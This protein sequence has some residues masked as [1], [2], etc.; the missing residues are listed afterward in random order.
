MNWDLAFWQAFYQS[1]NA[2]AAAYCIVAIGLN[3]H[4]GYTGLLNF[5]QAGFAAVGAYAFAVPIANYDWAWY[6]AIPV[7]VVASVLLSLLL[8]LPT[9]R[10]RADYLAIVTIAAAEIIRFSLNSTRFTWLT[11][12]SNGKQGW[13]R[14]FQDL[15]PWPNGGRYQIGAQVFDG[16]RLFMMVLGWSLVLLA[17]LLVWA[18]M[19]S[20]WGRVLKSIR[21]DEDAARALGKNVV[22]FKMQSLVLGGLLGSFGGLM[23]AAQTQA[24]TPGQYATNLTFF[25]FTIIVLGGLGRVA[26]PIIGTVLFF[27]VT[28]FIERLLSQATRNDTLPDWLVTTDNFSQVKYIIAGL[29][30]GA[31]IVFRPQGILGDR[32][33][34]VF[35]VR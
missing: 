16:Y 26:G 13:T 14:F 7:V 18:L 1:I 3:V 12:G 23:F 4:V 24:A 11:G 22:A 9:L 2:A 30:L 31:L 35:D 20:P 33:E 34:Q 17:S 25:S 5:G 8:G 19:R 28:Q 10:L 6:F 32:R 29:V 27:F 21:E 15:N